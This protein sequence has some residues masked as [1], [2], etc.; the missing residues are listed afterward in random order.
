MKNQKLENDIN[1]NEIYNFNYIYENMNKK[2]EFNLA[3]DKTNNKNRM[4]RLNGNNNSNKY[5]KKMNI[6]DNNISKHTNE[7]MKCKSVNNLIGININVNYMNKNYSIK[8]LKHN[9]KKINCDN[10]CGN[11]SKN[12]NNIIHNNNY[13]KINNE[14]LANS[15]SSKMQ[16]NKKCI[17]ILNPTNQALEKIIGD[18]KSKEIKESKLN[19]NESLKTEK[20]F[21]TF[22]GNNNTNISNDRITIY[23]KTNS[24]IIGKSSIS[25]N[26]NYIKT[27]KENNSSNKYIY[28][29][30][31]MNKRINKLKLKH[32]NKD[33]E[34][35]YNN[36]LLQILNDY[37]IEYN[38]L[39]ED[40]NQKKLIKEI[41]QQLDKIIKSKEEEII[42]IRKEN[43][44]LLKIN[45]SLKSKNEELLIYQNNKN[46]YD[47][48]N[49]K[50]G[51][52]I[53]SSN[54]NK[55]DSSPINS[56]ELES[57]KFCDKIIM[58]KS[59]FSNI[60]ELSFK[61]INKN[62]NEKNKD[63]PIKNNIFQKKHSFQEKNN[64]N[65]GINNCEI[66][67]KNSFEIKNKNINNINKKNDNL[68]LL[69]Q[70]SKILEKIE[71]NK[72]NIKSFI[73]NFVK[74]GNKK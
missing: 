67:N 41:Y 42:N 27:Q 46:E 64:R 70:K 34:H 4:K 54:N 32:E 20:I 33:F 68:Q 56:E 47:N 12:F 11:K 30:Q 35:N 45:E 9:S 73:N 48:S 24:N 21:E 16:L 23:S 5:S 25:K 61:N 37:F 58:E 44:D 3:N 31:K 62:N 71:R 49:N 13:C 53:S 69:F 74:S 43:E 19:I 28:L 7:L 65:K 18:L 29:Y 15:S 51:K 1:N 2:S 60:P 66:N 72:P 39:L 38:N 10:S 52:F 40:N 59:S 17:L 36:K 50:D 6:L 57:I 55:N 63:I 8:K 22:I 14:N 26:I